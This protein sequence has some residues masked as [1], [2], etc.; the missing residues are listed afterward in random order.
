MGAIPGFEIVGEAASGEEAVAAAASLVP[1]LVLMDI[2]MPGI[3]GIEATRRIVEARPETLAV[4]LSTYR[5]EDLPSDAR[6]C[7]AAAYVHK[8]DFGP[9]LL[10]E[11]F[12]RPI[13]PARRGRDALP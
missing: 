1:D 3:G 11:L 9:Q 2:K 8:A 10:R 4:L 13:D 7:G 5:A 12:T 6:S